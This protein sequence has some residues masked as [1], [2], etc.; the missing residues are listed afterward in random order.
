MSFRSRLTLFFVAIVIVP[1]ASMAVVLFRLLS[2]NEHGKGDARIAARQEAAIHLY[3][4]ARRNSSAVARRIAGN[5]KPLAAALR[6]GKRVRIQARTQELRRSYHVAR[7]LVRDPKGNTLADA[8]SQLA[9]FPATLQLIDQR[10]R[11]YG[12]IQVAVETAS[13]YVDL[14]HRIAGL[15]TIVIRD[16]K[17]IAGT[18]P[19]IDPADLPANQ[20]HVTAQSVDYRVS[21][22]PAPGFGGSHVQVSVL[23]NTSVT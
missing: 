11:S 14:V 22:F 8:G 15:D 2:D 10:R 3:E 17:R 9:T 19:Q 20:G 16:G 23:D 6:S 1:M 7:I 5:D 21:S 18:L 4:D 12:T 13:R